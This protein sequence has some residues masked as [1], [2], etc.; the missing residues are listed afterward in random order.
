M[1]EA[2]NELLSKVK[3]YKELGINPLALATGCAV[4]V[5]LLKVVYPA[6]GKLKP[7]LRSKGLTIAPREDADVF[8]KMEEIKLYRRIYPLGTSSINVED[9]KRISPS[10][11]IAVIQVYQRYAN[12]PEAFLKMLTPLYLKIAET[13][14]NIYLGKG[15]SIITPFEEDQFALFD[16]IKLSGKRLE[17][18][19]AVNNDTIH[20]IDPTEEPGDYKQISGA[21]SNSLNDIFVLGFC[22][23]LRIAPVINAPKEELREKIWKHVETYARKHSI[24]ILEVPQPT[25]GRLLMGSTVIGDS[26]KHPPT[27]ENNVNRGMKIIAT[28]PFGELAPINVFLSTIIDETIIDDLEEYGI[29]FKELE[30]MKNIAVNTIST[31]NIEVAKIINKYLPEYGES[32]NPEEHIALT[33]DI[34]GPGIYVIRELAEKANV[35]IKLHEIPLLSPRLSEIATKLYIIPNATSGTN[36]AYIIIASDS[37]ADDIVKDLRFKGLKARIIGEVVSKGQPKVIAPKTLKNYVNDQR[38]LGKFEL[39][40]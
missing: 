30:E 20:I 21:L 8:S 12:N 16:F 2:F 29:T 35:S 18:F 32:F 34:T 27:F 1:G 40:E 25:K 33:T 10:R 4:K 3:Q 7:K 26:L 13:G 39:R 5:D 14:M 37:I 31:P 28:R 19:T 17:G 22:E 15:H 11:A 36:G 24:K 6:I 9:L 38:V 23:N